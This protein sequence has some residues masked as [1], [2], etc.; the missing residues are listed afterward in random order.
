MTTIR[1]AT[2]ADF[3]GI[4]ALQRA[5]HRD[6]VDARTAADEGFVTWRYD[7]PTLRAL[8]D[9]AA[10]SVAVDD[11]T[12]QVV[13]YAISLPAATAR[14][15]GPDAEGHALAHPL[16]QQLARVLDGLTWDGTPVAEIDYVIM[17][18]VAVAPAYRGRG[19][20]RRLYAHYLAS[21]AR[22]Y[23]L[24]LTDI[25]AENARSRAAHA[26]IGWQE[27]PHKAEELN[28]WVVVGYDL[29]PLRRKLG[30]D[31]ARPG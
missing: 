19:V 20:F 29:K 23:D 16:A 13:A 15:D 8:D 25:H 3:D 4:L 21:R 12:E 28:D 17:G 1:P 22:H 31:E 27:V 26:A 9:P 14:G 18:Q 24:A 2:P 11:T 7:R 30:Q 6:A 10:H 5:A